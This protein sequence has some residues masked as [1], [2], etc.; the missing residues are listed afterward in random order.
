MPATKNTWPIGDTK[1]TE[2]KLGFIKFIGS[3]MNVFWLNSQGKPS[4]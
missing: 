2:I 1:L 4:V 3:N